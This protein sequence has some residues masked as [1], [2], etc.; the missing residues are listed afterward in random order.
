MSFPTG[1]RERAPSVEG[2][3][4]L[5][6]TVVIP[7]RNRGWLIAD[8]IRSVLALDR[9]DLQVLV[10]DQSTDDLTRRLIEG[11]AHGDERLTVV[12]S[13]TVGVSAARNLAVSLTRSD[14][15]AFIDDDCWVEPGWLDAMMAEFDDPRVVAVYGRVVPPGF[16]HRNG[17]EVAFKDSGRREQFE[18]RTPPWHVGHG[19]SRA[20]RRSA[21]VKAGGFDT[22]LGPGGTFGACEDLDIAYRLSAAGGR[23]VYTDLAVSYHKDWREWKARRRLERAYGVGAGAAFAKYLRSGDLYALKLLATWTWELGVR[24]AGAG[25]FKWRNYRPLVLGCY[26]LVYP[27][28]GMLRSFAYRIDRGAVVYWDHGRVTGQ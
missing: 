9:P 23:L 17:T 28:I 19:A 16:T 13:N 20:L 5:T 15:V 25:L 6:V 10:I 24:R 26:Q 22:R 27:W 3:T 8:A 14:I 21:V 7:T 12:P 18:G 4:P 11:E 1:A 2:R